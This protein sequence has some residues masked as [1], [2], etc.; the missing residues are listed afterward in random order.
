MLQLV[1][2]HLWHVVTGVHTV[3]FGVDPTHLSL[4]IASLVKVRN[5]KT[6]PS[7]IYSIETRLTSEHELVSADVRSQLILFYLLNKVLD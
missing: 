4:V 6:P 1:A 5:Q 2:T 3:S 7:H